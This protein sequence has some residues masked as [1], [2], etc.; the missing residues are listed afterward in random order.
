VNTSQK[1]PSIVGQEKWRKEQQ[2]RLKE[3]RYKEVLKIIRRRLP[4]D[5][6]EEKK[7]KRKKQEEKEPGTPVEKCYRYIAKRK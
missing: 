4:E 1:Q 7:N 5:W 2:E 6:E 3:S